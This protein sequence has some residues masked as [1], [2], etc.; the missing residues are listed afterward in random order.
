MHGQEL[1]SKTCYRPQWISFVGIKKL[2][3]LFTVAVRL[4]GVKDIDYAGRV[5]VFY[6]GRWGKICRNEWDID[7]AKV[8][9][10][11]LGFKSALAEFI[12][13]DTKDENVSIAMSNVACTGQEY[14]LASC[15]RL[16][17]EHKCVDNIGAQALCEPSKL[18][19]G[20]VENVR[21]VILC[22]GAYITLQ[23]LLEFH[24]FKPT[25]D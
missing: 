21:L 9:C 13:V 20:T 17:R 19:S 11:Q 15:K 8:V 5:E 10:K 6:E 14:V 23:G 22:C 1:K 12:K 25:E 3:S 24:G 4:A 7:D 2:M 16:D 18:K